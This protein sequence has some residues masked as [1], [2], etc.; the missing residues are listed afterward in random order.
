[1]TLP[2]TPALDDPEEKA[3][4]DEWLAERPPAVRAR[5][6]EYP[7][8]LYRNKAIADHEQIFLLLSW[9]EDKETGACDT[10]TVAV[11]F[12][13]NV[14]LV[15]ERRVF[16]VPFTDLE[17]I[18][19]HPDVV[20]ERITAARKGITVQQLRDLLQGG[21]ALELVPPGA[22]SADINLERIRARVKA[23]ESLSDQDVK[24]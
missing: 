11:L 1:M 13:F 16:G 5:A 10:C 4:W 21:A 18:I 12:K 15:C 2:W 14:S 19:D 17:P 20:A 3:A 24:P 8:G 7:P 9:T 23:G 22:D 6:L